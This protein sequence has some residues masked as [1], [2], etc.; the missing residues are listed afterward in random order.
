MTGATG[1]LGKAVAL[2]FSREGARLALLARDRERLEAL[3][4]ELG[5]TTTV[6][7][8][9]AAGTRPSGGSRRRASARGLDVS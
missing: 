6:R 7:P 8:T 1:G 3:R 9:S 5:E 2:A 4:A